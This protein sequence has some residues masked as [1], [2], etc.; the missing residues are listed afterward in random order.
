[1]GRAGT[2]AAAVAQCVERAPRPL[3]GAVRACFV[4]VVADDAEDVAHTAVLL[5]R[6]WPGATM[7]GAAAA[8]AGRG[9]GGPAVALT[10]TGLDADA[11]DHVVPLPFVAHADVRGRKQ[12]GRYSGARAG[13]PAPS[14]PPTSLAAGQGGD[15]WARLDGAA[16]PPPE[17]LQL[18]APLLAAAAADAD[19]TALPLWLAM[20]DAAEVALLALDRALPRSSKVR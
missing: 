20:G 12:V 16:A 10:V 11:E 19:Q 7:V 8:G 5:R 14:M 9:P 2:V 1:V 4:A 3:P 17:S 6:G 13:P 15:R 18:P